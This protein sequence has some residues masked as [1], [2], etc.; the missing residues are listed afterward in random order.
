MLR[1]E[2]QEAAAAVLNKQNDILKRIKRQTE[3]ERAVK[4]MA[5]TVLDAI[6]LTILD[7]KF[8]P[9]C[10]EVAIAYKF[11]DRQAPYKLV[12]KEEP[13]FTEEEWTRGLTNACQDVAK[14][15][16]KDQIDLFRQL[17]DEVHTVRKAIEELDE[18]LDS[19]VLRR[20]LLLTRCDLCPA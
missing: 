7:G 16:L 8:N 11:V 12:S 4:W 2:A 9:E 15:L 3:E 5:R 20:L 18:M 17:C 1:P 19:L 13:R 14:I 6:W 10:P